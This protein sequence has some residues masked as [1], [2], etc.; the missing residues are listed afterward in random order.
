MA[1]TPPAID[2]A[3]RLFQGGDYLSSALVDYLAWLQRRI[4]DLESTGGNPDLTN[5]QLRNEKGV[6]NGYPTLDATGIVPLSELPPI[7]PGPPGATGPAGP[8]GPQGLQGP[9]GPTGPTGPQGGAGPAGPQGPQGPTG[10]TPDLSAYQLLSARGNPN[11]YPS[12]D[13]TGKVPLAQLPA[14]GA[15]T[16]AIPGEIRMWGGAAIPSG[17]GN[18]VWADGTAYPN[19]TYPSAAA[20]IAAAW[21][22]FA[23]AVDPGG[24]NFRVPD[25]RGLVAIAL[26]AMP[27]GARANRLSRAVAATLAGRTGEE[28]HTLSTAELASHNHGVNDPQ[29]EHSASVTAA[30]NYGADGSENVEVGSPQTH[31]DNAGLTVAMSY[32]ATGVTVQANG[33]GGAHENVPPAVFV[34]YIVKLDG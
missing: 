29:H 4:S 24:S 8:G 17:Y 14:I 2:N 18:W 34:P 20:N 31:I 30:Y 3:E 7:S 26:D 1:V 23:G 12:L 33:G 22:T 5:Y 13:P 32:A 6:A 9:I 21:R 19:A 16:A 10:V 27:G 11:G 28:Y 15:A 25:L